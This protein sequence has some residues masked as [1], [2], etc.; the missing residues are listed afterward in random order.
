MV[1][2]LWHGGVP[3]WLCIIIPPLLF[4]VSHAHHIYYQSRHL[5][6]PSN[7]SQAWIRVAFQLCY[8]SIFG[9]LASIIF[10]RTGNVFSA[11]LMH[12]WCNCMGFPPFTFF[13]NRDNLSQRD[14]INGCA[15]V[16]GLVGFISLLYPFTNPKYFN[17]PYQ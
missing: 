9:I 10:M 15:Y 3:Y 5:Y 1:S 6:E 8:T 2:L 17:S 12:V 14:I 7:R 11:M 4:G 16:I 13:M